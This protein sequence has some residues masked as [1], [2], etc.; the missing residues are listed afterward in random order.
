MKSQINAY[1][2]PGT[3]YAPRKKTDALFPLPAGT[4]HWEGL[5]DQTARRIAGQD[6]SDPRFWK[7]FADQF[8]I[9]P[10]DGNNLWRSEYWGK[11]MRGACITQQYLCDDQLYTI[12]EET[13][14]D[15]LTT[16]D[17]QGR[18]ASYN[19]EYQFNGWDIWG[20]KYVLL[21]L[22]HFMEISRD[23]ALNE[24]I[25]CAM[26]KHTDIMIKELA[27]SGKELYETSTYWLGINASSIL[28]PI[29]RL[30]S[31]TGE[32]RYLDYAKHIVEGGGAVGFDLFKEPLRSELP[33]SQYPVVKAYEMMS[34]FEG[35]LEYGRV[36]GDQSAIEAVKKL[37]KRILADEI[38]VI[39]SAGCV[40]ELFDGARISQF[41]EEKGKG[42]MQET[43][44][45]VTWMKFCLQLLSL[46]GD[47]VYADAMETSYYNA[48][49]GAVN[50]RSIPYN[51]EKNS[52]R[53]TDKQIPQVF[54]FDS[55]SPLTA[56]IRG[57]K[58]GGYLPITEKEHYT[59]CTAI[60]SAGTG[61]MARYAVL[62]GENGPAVLFYEN[63]TVHFKT[64]KG[65]D[66]T[67]TVKTGWPY[68]SETEITL[69]LPEEEEF[70]LYL[71]IPGQSR[72]ETRTQTW[73]DGDTVRLTF[74]IQTSV[75][76]SSQLTDN[77][78]DPHYCLK[79]G[80]IVLAADTEVSP[81][82]FESRTKPVETAS[83]VAAREETPQDEYHLTLAVTLDDGTELTVVDY[84][85]AGKSWAKDKPIA[86]WL[87]RK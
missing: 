36:T 60:A 32:Q 73:K 66:A 18:I 39:G 70:S 40:H 9:R 31:I 53:F 58:Q 52:H 67:L 6:T 16:A 87:R 45:T 12:L 69:S 77:D 43:C 85:S 10:D 80:I 46:T 62:Y 26:K 29:V 55:Y 63:G 37:S 7:I 50:T 20:R 84:A 22:Q 78:T 3:A 14:R 11:M 42:I 5:I 19:P 15:L 51:P 54:P 83:L 79:R 49:L 74:E 72:W 57:K 59:C 21:G 8:R 86:C 24:E 25:V 35:L 34:C 82:D 27:E 38:S 65:Q 13:V 4:A 1:C 48:L 41:D 68:E 56:G 17:D 44:V 47:P 30:Y 28:E 81:F 64:P 61:I 76:Y 23:P 71:R 75:L 33:P 2:A